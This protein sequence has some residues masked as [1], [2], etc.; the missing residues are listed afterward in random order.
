MFCQRQEANRFRAL[1]PLGA[2]H[3]SPDTTSSGYISELCPRGSAAASIFWK[4]STTTIDFENNFDQNDTVTSFNIGFRKNRET[5]GYFSTTFSGVTCNEWRKCPFCKQNYQY[6]LCY[7]WPALTPPDLTLFYIS[8]AKVKGGWY[9]FP[10]R[11]DPNCARL[12]QQ[13]E[14]VFRYDTQRFVVIFKVSVQ[15][16]PSEVKSMTQVS[17]LGF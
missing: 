15:P 12:P 14:H 4:S 1:S 8:P 10:R 7:F 2:S 17:G 16:L 5:N 3:N 13:N 9:E 6:Y 11:F